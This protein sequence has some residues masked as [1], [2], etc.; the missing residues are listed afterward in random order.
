MNL[1]E[2]NNK[3]RNKT[4]ISIRKKE[5]KENEMK[6]QDAVGGIKYI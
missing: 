4:G 6:H 3:R 2:I 5:R 1:G